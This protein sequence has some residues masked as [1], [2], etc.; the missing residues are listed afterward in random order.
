MTN[1]NE[2]ISTTSTCQIS[3]DMYTEMNIKTHKLLQNGKR[4]VNN[5][6]AEH[7]VSQIKTSPLSIGINLHTPERMKLNMYT[8]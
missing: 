7:D 5:L 6:D 4:L 2:N 1:D 3:N 8:V